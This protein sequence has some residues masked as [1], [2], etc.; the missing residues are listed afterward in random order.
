MAIF[1]KYN[2]V[3]VLLTRYLGA[4]RPRAKTGSGALESQPAA[5]HAHGCKKRHS[6]PLRC[7]KARASREPSLVAALPTRPA[8]P[9]QE[10]SDIESLPEEARLLLQDKDALVN[11]LQASHDAHTIRI[12]TLEDRLIS[13]ELRSANEL[14]S[15]VSE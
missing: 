10:N 5:P 11:A 3:R 4:P 6:L 15:G 8:W 7:V 1:E 2:Q 14:A 12:D 9:L 13:T